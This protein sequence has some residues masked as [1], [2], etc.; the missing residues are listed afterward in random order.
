VQVNRGLQLIMSK[1]HKKIGILGF[2]FNARTDDL[3]ESP[4][5]EVIERLRGKGYDLRIYDKNVKLASLVGA[6]CDY[7]L[8]HIPHIS[9]LMV[10]GGAGTCRDGVPA[11][12][13]AGQRLVDF[14][15]ISERRSHDGKYE[16]ICW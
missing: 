1:E 6:N 7:V 5:I 13:R 3:R 10:G 9:R 4:V 12:M 15:R 8:N 11:R 2:S 14:V 16:G